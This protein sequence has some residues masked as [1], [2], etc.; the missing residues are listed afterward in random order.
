MTLPSVRRVE[1]MLRAQFPHADI[2]VE[3]IAGGLRIE[4]Y[5]DASSL[6]AIVGDEPSAV[7][8]ALEPSSE[9]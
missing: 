2:N 4:V 5:G 3:R 1:A 9:P 8:A 6:F 7:I